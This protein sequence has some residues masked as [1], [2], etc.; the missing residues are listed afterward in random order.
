MK[1]NII[2]TLSGILLIG[3]I[4]STSV[5]ANTLQ[6]GWNKYNQLSDRTV[7]GYV[8]SNKTMATGWCFINNEWYYFNDEGIGVSGNAYKDA[9]GKWI[10]LN[11][12]SFTINGK[13]YY[14]DNNGTLIR[15]TDIYMGS[16][17]FKYHLDNNG[18]FQDIY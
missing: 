5:S 6:V 17:N 12:S 8:Y 14:F 15:N 1:K 18:D 7:W 10:N 4:F 11:S 3:T 16:G 13:D 9:N 2:K